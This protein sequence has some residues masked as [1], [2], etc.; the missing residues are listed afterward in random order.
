MLSCGQFDVQGCT[1]L[2][3]RTFLFLP[4]FFF[5]FSP[6]LD[7]FEHRGSP[8]GPFLSARSQTSPRSRSSPNPNLPRT[9][10]SLLIFPFIPFIAKRTKGDEKTG[11]SSWQPKCYPY[12]SMISVQTG[13]MGDTGKC[14]HR[15][16]KDFEWRGRAGPGVRRG[17]GPLKKGA[18]PLRPCNAPGEVIFTAGKEKQPA[19]A[20]ARIPGFARLPRDSFPFS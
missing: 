9:R 16:I 7:I 15:G 3:Y 14:K 17:T 18:C 11:F 5:L 12:F 6:V 19:H 4:Q 2:T 20:A 8:I 10:Y 13:D 1:L